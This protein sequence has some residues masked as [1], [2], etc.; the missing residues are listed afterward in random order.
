[1]TAPF[2]L[3][4]P[5]STEAVARTSPS[6]PFGSPSATSASV[7]TCSSPRNRITITPWVERPSRLISSAAI[8][9]TVPPVEIII[10]CIPSRTMRAPASWPF[11]SVSW[12]VFT[13][14]PPRPLRG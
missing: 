12:T 8:R 5:P 4:T 14:R 13:P 7:E 1:M 6:S 9:I 3:S 11:A 10:T 2:V